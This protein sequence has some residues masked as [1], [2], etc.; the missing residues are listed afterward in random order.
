MNSALLRSKE[1]QKRMER[2]MKEI[3]TAIAFAVLLTAVPALAADTSTDN[4]ARFFNKFGSWRQ[5]RARQQERTGRAAELY[6]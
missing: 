4:R 5:R 6:G 1:T 2:P 3:F